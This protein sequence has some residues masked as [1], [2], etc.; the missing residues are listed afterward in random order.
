MKKCFGKTG[1]KYYE[2]FKLVSLRISDCSPPPH[3]SIFNLCK[4]YLH[5]EEWVLNAKFKWEFWQKA[6]C[7]AH[8]MVPTKAGCSAH[9]M[10]PTKAGCSALI[11]WS[12]Q[13]QAV[14]RSSYGSKK[15][16]RSTTR[17]LSK[18]LIP[19]GIPGFYH[20]AV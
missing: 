15:I 18:L 16:N 6:G 9:P 7:S 1:F 12:L 13:K 8:P 19:I 2:R 17:N 14:A 11:P 5:S 20:I 4:F 3:M 10:V